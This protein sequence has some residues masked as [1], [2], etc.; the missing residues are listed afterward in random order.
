MTLQNENYERIVQVI[1]AILEIE[2]SSIS[3]DSSIETLEEWDSVSHM[4]LVLA[5]EQEFDV[6]FSDDQ[7]ME[8]LSVKKLSE[9]LASITQ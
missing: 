6:E 4:N 1:S 3:Q 5:M 2:T 9:T 8:V 7:M